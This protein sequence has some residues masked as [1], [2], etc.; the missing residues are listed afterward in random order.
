MRH[1]EDVAD[2]LVDRVLDH[3][4]AEH[5]AVARIGDRRFDA[6][7]AAPCRTGRSFLLSSRPMRSSIMLDQVGHAVGHRRVGGERSRWPRRSEAPAAGVAVEVLG[8]RDE[9]AQDVEF[10]RHDFA[11]AEDHLGEFLEAEHPERQV[12]RAGIDAHAVFRAATLANS[13][14]GSR[15]RTRRSGR[16]SIALRSSSDTAV[17]LPT[18]VVPTTAKWRASVSSMAMQASMRLVLRQ[19]AD[20]DGVAGRRDRRPPA[21][22]GCGCGG[23]RR[24]YADRR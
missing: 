7:G 1:A 21:G 9:V 13:L 5:E 18:P 3:P 23:R 19:V 16:A 12:E 22:R 24:R 17:D 11:A 6:G 14:C 8:E 20:G 10:L 4:G 2:R 15:I